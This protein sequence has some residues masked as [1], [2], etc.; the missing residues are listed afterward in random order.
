MRLVGATKMPLHLIGIL[1]SSATTRLSNIGE[2]L[3]FKFADNVPLDI[4]KAKQLLPCPLIS[5]LFRLHKI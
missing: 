5:G 4:F 3:M 2:A 1:I